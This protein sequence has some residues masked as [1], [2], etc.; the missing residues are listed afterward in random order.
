MT[1]NTNSNKKVSYFVVHLPRGRAKALFTVPSDLADILI[2]YP[3][4]CRGGSFD[5]HIDDTINNDN[6]DTNADNNKT[7]YLSTEYI[8]P[9][10]EQTAQAISERLAIRI[11]SSD[12]SGGGSSSSLI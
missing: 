10:P 11:G 6:D 12:G 9:E 7:C 2:R 1:N 3:I 8:S 5:L 4:L